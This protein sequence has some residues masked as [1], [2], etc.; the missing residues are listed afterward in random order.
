MNRRQFLALGAAGSASAIGL[1]GCASF[2]GVKPLVFEL[3]GKLSNATMHWTNVMLQAFRSRNVSPLVASRAAAMAHLAGYSAVTGDSFGVFQ[4]EVVSS[5]IDIE[6]AYGVAFAT[7]LEE[8]LSISL[9][10][11]RK[12]FL[13]Q[14]NSKSAQTESATWGESQALQVIKWRTKDGAEDALSRIYPAQYSKREDELAWTPTG[15][16]YGARNGPSF[17]TF[18]R[19]LRPAWGA[20]KTWLI[21]SVKQFE[22]MPFP[23]PN[24]AEF[25]RQFEKVKTLGASD[26]PVRTEQQSEIALFWEDGLMGI[27]IAGHFQLI[28]MQLL[29]QRKL[30]LIEEARLLALNSIALADAVIVAWHNKYRTDIIRPETAIRHAGSRFNHLLP[31]SSWKSYI[32]TPNF[33]TYVSGHS[34]FGA[35]ACS[36]MCALLGSDQIDLASPAPDMVNWPSQLKSVRRHYNSLTQIAEENGM[37]REYGGVHWEI[38]NQEGLRLGYAVTDAILKKPEVT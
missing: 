13:S 20:Q 28:A 33:P 21:N 34:A 10:F 36:M 12:H 23:E 27:T 5:T 8:A 1:S 19:G 11:E 3:D 4:T 37:S 17:K 26:S 30:N 18:E 6:V 38:D 29:S 9:L 2:S 25:K 31:D 16:F 7:A 14:H 22:A 24:S 32:P 35:A 15:P